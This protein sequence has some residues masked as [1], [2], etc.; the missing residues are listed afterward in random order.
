MFI[1]VDTH[2]DTLAACRVGGNGQQV[3][4]GTFRNNELGHAELLEWARQAESPVRVGIE[5]AANFGAGLAQ[6]LYAHNIDVRE[7]PCKL[8]GRER[9]RLRRPGKSDPS[10]A[11]AIARVVAREQDLPPARRSGAHEDL[12]VLVDAR[13]ELVV[14]RTAESNRLHADLAILAPG[15]H[16]QPL[17]D[18][19]GIT[20]AVRVLRGRVEVRAQIARRR[21]ARLRRLDR[22]IVELTEQIKHAVSA[23]GTTLTSIVGV[24][25]LTAARLL[26]EVGDIRRYPSANHFAAG[27]GTAPIPVCS[28]RTDRHRLN[29]GGNRR[30]NRAVHTAARTQ[31]QWDPRAKDYMDR[32]RAEGKTRAEA[33]RCLKRRLSDVLYRTMTNDAKSTAC[34]PPA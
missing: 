34:P 4:E 6:V 1:G 20:A 21:V 16:D 8:T 23:T 14:Q 13:D 22:E 7:V 25:A 2:K 3:D 29:R 19:A 31:A 27:N 17:V 12:K 30:L 32:K 9:Q 28:G 5:G 11:L 18:S 26:G 24:G 15:Q 10:D 33:L